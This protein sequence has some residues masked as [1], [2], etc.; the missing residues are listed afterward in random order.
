MKTACLILFLTILSAFGA[1]NPAVQN[2]PVTKHVANP[3]GFWPAQTNDPLFILA[4][5]AVQILPG[6]GLATNV[7]QFATFPGSG[8]I[9]ATNGLIITGSVDTNHIKIP[10][11]N[12]VGFA[13]SSAY[14]NFIL[15]SAT[16]AAAAVTNGMSL[17]SFIATL[18]GRGTNSAIWNGTNVGGFQVQATAAGNPYYFIPQLTYLEIGRGFGGSTLRASNVWADTFFGPDGN[19]L[20]L[21]SAAGVSTKQII[22]TNTTT[23]GFVGEGS[24][25][26][27]LQVTA[28]AVTGTP[29]ATK[30]LFGDR[31]D[32]VSG[33]S[34][35]NVLQVVASSRIGVLTN[36]LNRTPFLLSYYVDSVNGSD[37][38]DGLTPQSAWQTLGRL[39]NTL[40]SAD[41]RLARGSH[42]REQL[43]L[44]T[45]CTVSAYGSGPRPILDASDVKTG[46]TL[47]GAFTNV[48]AV[49]NVV[50]TGGGSERRISV[51][52]D[53]DILTIAAN[54]ASCETNAG[55]YYAALDP[56]AGS[57]NSVFVHPTDGSTNHLFEV[58]VRELGLQAGN[59]CTVRS[60]HTRNNMTPGGSI[61]L[62]EDCY[63]Q[64]VFAENGTKHN[65]FIASGVVEDCEAG[66][67]SFDSS[68]TLFVAYS[69]VDGRSVVFRRCRAWGKPNKPAVA[70]AY[71]GHTGGAVGAYTN[72]LF[73]DCAADYTLGFGGVAVL[74]NGVQVFNRCST[75]G[76]T[77]SGWTAYGGTNIYLDCTFL[78]STTP[79]FGSSG[80]D[81]YVLISGCKVGGT[82]YGVRIN[83]NRSHVYIHDSFLSGRIDTTAGTNSTYI[84]SNTVIHASLPI[85]LTAGNT[86]SGNSNCYPAFG[87]A[88]VNGVTY[89][90]WGEYQ[91]ALSPT[92]ANSLT[93]NLKLIGNTSNGD[94]RY[95]YDSPAVTNLAGPG[96]RMSYSP[97]LV[98]DSVSRSIPVRLASGRDP[99]TTFDA[100]TNH[101]EAHFL[102]ATNDSSQS[103]TLYGAKLS[104]PFTNTTDSA[105]FVGANNLDLY[106]DKAGAA[107]NL[108]HH[109]SIAGTDYGEISL[110]PSDATF[111]FQALNGNGVWIV[112]NNNPVTLLG[113]GSGLD[114]VRFADTS[115]NLKYRMSSSFDN[116]FDSSITITN[117][118]E[119]FIGNG[120]GLSNVTASAL[121]A[122]VTNWVL[123]IATNAA[124]GA[125]NDLLIGANLWAG[126]NDFEQ[127]VTLT[128]GLIANG[129]ITVESNLTLV[130]GIMSGN[131]SGLSNVTASS[132]S[133][134]YSNWVVFIAREASKS[135]YLSSVTQSFGVTVAT[136]CFTMID[137][138]QAA[139]STNS[140]A[141]SS[142]TNY[143]LS[144]VSTNTISS[145][146]EGPAVLHTYAQITGGG[147]VQTVTAHPELYL[148]FTNDT[149]VEIATSGDIVY[150]EADGF[151]A[152]QVT[153]N[154]LGTSNSLP[155]GTRLMLRWKTTA[156]ANS[157]TWSFI[158]GGDYDSH[159]TI[160]Q[161]ASL[162]GDMRMS[163]YD[164]NANNIVDWV[165]H[166]ALSA[167]NTNGAS[168]GAVPTMTGSNVSWAIPSG[169]GNVVDTA[170]ND[171][172]GS[173]AFHGATW[174]GGS[175]TVDNGNNTLTA[176]NLS[177]TGW[178]KLAGTETNT[179][180]TTGFVYADA[181]GG[182]SSTNPPFMIASQVG[183]QIGSSNL[184]TAELVGTQIGSSNLV[185]AALV[186]TQIASSNLLTAALVGTQIASSNL[187]TAAQVGTQI[188]SS[189]L[190]TA[191]QV[192]TQIGGS[193]L[194][195]LAQAAVITNSGQINNT[196]P[197]ANVLY[198]WTQIATPT[199]TIPI[200]NGCSYYDIPATGLRVDVTNTSGSGSFQ[201]VVWRNTNAAATAYIYTSA[202]GVGIYGTAATT[203]NTN[204]LAVPATKSAVQVFARIP[205]VETNYSNTVKQ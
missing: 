204:G 85:N 39:S 146:I 58:A 97:A 95:G 68:A 115:G 63:A 46:W 73:E 90:T 81:N 3:K 148:W 41:I 53:G 145:I 11:S 64:D 51:I 35:T 18:N 40:N 157:P 43:T 27:N 1:V 176:S 87:Q 15:T 119:Q 24:G 165:D 49:S 183:T 4:V 125:T 57:T 23:A 154:V 84:V 186:G 194:I 156:Q 60:I 153:M 88:V 141:I 118:A 48:Y 37:A 198:A 142:G 177:V 155:S 138:P 105:R 167:L 162:V 188:A 86:V 20:V 190:L 54:L 128:S 181:S 34:A 70:T 109:F 82:D 120:G 79:A 123:T 78:N 169:S 106:F 170:N 133:S 71:Y 31:W 38:K 132:T 203:A 131:G 193:N 72:V 122:G 29:D 200:T 50:V 121:V 185:T 158:V 6:G 168:V 2:D 26:T 80:S 17:G 25:L 103:Q 201:T 83:Q 99:H 137:V 173:N 160:G 89:P 144:R 163:V 179:T 187:L 126:Q 98:P 62:G 5:Q 189:N 19:P 110:R 197:S 108:K 56:V 124:H 93:N 159:L 117:P 166:V 199:N 30:V 107:N 102:V 9:L 171:F 184:L 140:I 100:Y 113:G 10:W 44:G 112:G 134:A 175:V 202:A 94:F 61:V 127:P 92:D 69:V 32:V 28:I 114:I 75:Y 77:S 74:T 139:L 147:G 164:T 104:G 42:W 195:T 14:T 59:N 52:E 129:G 136:N 111:R 45:N 191:A 135:Y 143:F 8:L 174:F 65:F 47:A 151:R 149:L 180:I 66:K 96:W 178:A 76:A 13:L 7:Y 172:T 101:A 152:V 22:A 91:A 67:Q 36:G 16:N 21:L 33:G 130:S 205:N 12:V 182:R 196:L 116:F 192:G 55:T 161:T 150:S